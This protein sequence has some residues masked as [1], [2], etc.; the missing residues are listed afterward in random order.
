MLPPGKLLPELLGELL[1]ELRGELLMPSF[2]LLLEL[3][4][5]LPA[6][7]VP[8]PRA[9]AMPSAPAPATTRVNVF[10]LGTTIVHLIIFIGNFSCGRPPSILLGSG[11]AAGIKTMTIFSSIIRG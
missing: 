4:D 2:K 10:V 11:G 1:L 8:A 3:L 6:E 5:E 7:A 9:I